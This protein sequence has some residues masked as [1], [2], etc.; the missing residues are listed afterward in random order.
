MLDFVPTRPQLGGHLHNLFGRRATHTQELPLAKLI[1]YFT[2]RRTRTARAA[3]DS[4]GNHVIR[5]VLSLQ[6]FVLAAGM[7]RVIDSIKKVMLQN[8]L[9]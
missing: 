2:C 6:R 3:V 7:S 9:E 4:G 8:S 5:H 1:D